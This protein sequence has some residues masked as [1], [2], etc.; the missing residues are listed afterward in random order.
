M[1]ESVDVNNFDALTICNYKLVFADEQTLLDS[2]L[3]NLLVR[4]VSYE[5]VLSM[6]VC[7]R[8]EHG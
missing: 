6:I 3:Q 5:H 8:L 2:P 4:Q 1:C 7:H